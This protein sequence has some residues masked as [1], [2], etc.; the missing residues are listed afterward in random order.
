MDSSE[1][2]E[3]LESNEILVLIE[4]WIYGEGIKDIDLPEGF[5]CVSSSRPTS[6]TSLAN[7]HGGIMILARKRVQMRVSTIPRI[8]INPDHLW[9]SVGDLLLGTI[10]MWPPKSKNV[11]D[12]EVMSS[13][14]GVLSIARGDPARRI[15]VVGDF[16]ARIGSLQTVDGPARET[17]DPFHSGRGQPFVKLCSDQGM[18]ILNGALGTDQSQGGLATSLHKRRDGGE[19]RTVIDFAITNKEVVSAVNNFS[20]RE[21]ARTLSDH[22]VTMTEIQCVLD[23]ESHDE[24]GASRR[25]KR[26]REQR[27]Y[28]PSALNNKISA[29]RSDNKSRLCNRPDPGKDDPELA[30]IARYL[31]A[32]EKSFREA[33][34]APDHPER[35]ARVAEA[36]KATR[37][38]KQRMKRRRNTIAWKKATLAPSSHRFFQLYKKRTAEAKPSKGSPTA[39]PEEHAKHYHD[40]GQPKFNPNHDAAN[41]ASAIEEEA[42]QPKTTRN[43]DSKHYLERPFARIE[44]VDIIEEIRQRNSAG[45]P[46]GATWK[47]VAASDVTKLLELLNSCIVQQSIPEEWKRTTTIP[48]PKDS[49]T[50]T[51][52]TTYRGITL[53]SCYLKVLTMLLTRRMAASS[54][55]KGL[56]PNEQTGFRTRY[57]TGINTFVLSQILQRARLE[58]RDLFVAFVDLKKAFDSVSRPLLWAKLRALGAQGRLFDLIRSIYGSLESVVRAGGEESDP[59]SGEMG[60]L[61]GDSLS[62]V[63]WDLFISDFVLDSAQAYQNDLPEVSPGMRI[64]QTVFA[65]DLNLMAYT[66]KA[67]QKSMNDFLAYCN[68]NHLNISTTKTVV[69]RFDFSTENKGNDAPMQITLDGS[70]LRQVASAKYIGVEMEAGDGH[71]ALK[72]QKHIDGKASA[73]MGI[74]HA[75]MSI[76]RHAGI[77]PMRMV[78]TLYLTRVRSLMTFASEITFNCDLSS[79]ERTEK[80]FLRAILAQPQTSYVEGLYY[81]LGLFPIAFVQLQHAVRFYFY[82]AG[83]GPSMIALWATQDNASIPVQGNANRRTPTWFSAL[84]KRLAEMDIELPQPGDVQGLEDARYVILE[85]MAEF[86][87]ARMRKKM[88]ESTRFVELRRKENEFRVQPYLSCLTPAQREAITRIRFSTDKFALQMGRQEKP[89]VERS[90]R[91]CRICDSDDVED[92]YH[93]AS[94]CMGSPELE[95]IRTDF[96]LDIARLPDEKGA[97]GRE[98]MRRCVRT[99]GNDDLMRMMLHSSDATAILLFGKFALTVTKLFYQIPPRYR[100][101]API[102]DPMGDDESN[103]EEGGDRIKGNTDDEEQREY[104]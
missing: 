52:P 74:A 80:V 57:R 67:L 19:T 58:G 77:M 9:V 11:T 98:E 4:T 13:F 97:P 86:E 64:G 25:K 39:T 40:L 54:D 2:R 55:S 10:Y 79:M 37:N 63:L 70:L 50:N 72:F 59:F 91:T 24:V 83:M 73:G 84:S 42:T 101:R 82:A 6:L 95:E 27:E 8:N 76:Q 43:E 93:A 81:E 94:F 35:A 92:F 69:L 85:A 18:I 3:L 65:D 15:L 38:L 62:G 48:I 87:K 71:R 20:V 90:D 51:D 53:E 100:G 12:S 75:A 44:V 33:E 68:K 1:I 66:I 36:L 29:L 32:A 21:L 102:V 23:K 26:N 7:P 46:D 41:L 104:D 45:V 14:E 34:A 56:L 31:K 28:S 22:A 5:D 96:L 30:E 60:V 78:R 88:E 17:H 89:K 99:G 103:D 49:T 61:Q 16:N 47:E